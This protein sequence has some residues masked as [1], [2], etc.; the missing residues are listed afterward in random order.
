MYECDD[1]EIKEVESAIRSL[2]YGKAAGA[3]RVTAKMI[4]CG[5]P[6]VF[7]Y[8]YAIYVKNQGKSQTIREVQLSCLC[9]KKRYT[10]ILRKL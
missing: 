1:G 7:S 10:D 8:F 2:K 5:G 4:K 3:Y 9:I 6:R